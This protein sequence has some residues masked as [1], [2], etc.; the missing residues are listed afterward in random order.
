MPPTTHPI[1]SPPRHAF[2]LIELLVVIAVMGLLLGILIPSLASARREAR[3]VPCAANL[4]AVGQAMAA[5]LGQSRTYPASYVYASEQTG[6]NWNM[7][8]QSGSHSAP[9]NGYVH[10]SSVLLGDG[11]MVPDAAFRCPSAPRGG[12]PATNPGGGI[13][14]WDTELNQTNDMGSSSPSEP[15]RDRQATRM[16][17]TA[18]AAIMPRNKFHASTA[19]KNRLVPDSAITFPARTILATELVHK[20]DW[21]TVFD[22]TK[23]RSHR[24]I[25]PFL[26]ITQGDDVYLQ[27]DGGA[28]PAFVYAARTTIIPLSG[29]REDMLGFGRNP[30][31]AVGRSH[32]GGGKWV[33]GT[34]NFVFIDGHGERMSVLDSLEKKLWGDKFFSMTGSNTGV[35]MTP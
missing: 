33:G 5:Y 2:T 19:R 25:T 28:G 20:N 35:R 7:A 4:R 13:E 18:N 6:S 21:R 26:G 1:P 3:A 32:P 11:Q 23:S 16:A 27:P 12:A 29:I 22:G 10:W 17:Y 30:L 15:P 24:P 8:D 9:L 34:A 31:N 14:N